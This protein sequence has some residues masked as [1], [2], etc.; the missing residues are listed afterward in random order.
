MSSL[1]PKI[2]AL[3]EKHKDNKEAQT[4]ALMELYQKE[5]ISPFSGCLPILIQLPIL[6]TLYNVL[7]SSLKTVNASDIYPFLSNFIVS[8]KEPYSFLGL[9]NMATPNIFLAFLAGV[10]QLIQSYQMVRYQNFKSS[11]PSD[12]AASLNKNMTFILPIMTFFISWKLPAA[13]ALYWATTTL[14][15]IFQQLYIVYYER[16]NKIAN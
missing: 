8:F 16:K 7:I 6:W 11:G 14:I 9:V 10:L 5:K 15:S 13:L 1:S 3:K 4:K 2:Q 12:I